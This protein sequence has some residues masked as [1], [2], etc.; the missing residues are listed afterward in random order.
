MPT[1]PFPPTP[2]PILTPGERRFLES[3]RTAILGTT[4]ERG[5]PRLVPICFVLAFRDDLLGRPVLHSPIDE[6]PKSDPD[7]HKLQRVQDLH[8]RPEVTLLVE[9]WDEDWTQLAWLRLYGRGELLE[10]A[11]RTAAEHGA[12][13]RALRAKYPQYRDHALERRPIIRL[14][15][16]EAR[17]WGAIG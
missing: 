4:D 7:P 14:T 11:A 5:R 10:P 3:R 13:V 9:R 6:K 8:A 12:A 1:P 15:I 16:D 17:S 2:P